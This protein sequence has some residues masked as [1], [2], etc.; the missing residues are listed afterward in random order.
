MRIFL[1]LFLFAVSASALHATSLSTLSPLDGAAGSISFPL[2]YGTS[3]LVAVDFTPL[4]QFQI[5]NVELVV[6]SLSSCQLSAQLVN[7]STLC[8]IV[9]NGLPGTLVV[10]TH[11]CTGLFSPSVFLMN[12]TSTFS[13]CLPLTVFTQIAPVIPINIDLPSSAI[14]YKYDTLAQNGWFWFF[15][16]SHTYSELPP[17][18]I[19]VTPLGDTRF[20]SNYFIPGSQTPGGLDV[21]STSTQTIGYVDSCVN[22]KKYPPFLPN[23]TLIQIQPAAVSQPS[24]NFAEFQAFSFIELVSLTL[25]GVAITTTLEFGYSRVFSFTLDS[26]QGSGVEFSLKLLSGLGEGIFWYVNGS[27]LSG[28]MPSLDANTPLLKISIPPTVCLNGPCTVLIQSDNGNTDFE[29][30]A[31]VITSGSF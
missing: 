19:G 14:Q 20:F 30:S 10:I 8:G 6:S 7:P 16:F 15:A 1:S 5:S 26:T 23:G 31:R 13:S 21:G 25:D 12:I 4:N 2:V 3:Q 29:G 24:Q 28:N 11:W 9:T 18:A 27:I 17:F 22:G